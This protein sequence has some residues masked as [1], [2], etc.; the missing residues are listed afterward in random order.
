MSHGERDTS[1]AE[2]NCVVVPLTLSEHELLRYY[3]GS[4]KTV[5]AKDIH[6]KTVHFP[7]SILQ[8]FISHIGVSGVFVI[9]FDPSGRFQRIVKE[10]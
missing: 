1:M 10:R 4:A 2:E 6:G 7:L 9:Y 3:R 8:P 5:C